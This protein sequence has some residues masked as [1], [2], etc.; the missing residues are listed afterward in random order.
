M[1]DFWLKII[2]TV[3]EECFLENYELAQ[4][5]Q[6]TLS[7]SDF[8]GS[9]SVLLLG[10]TLS[11]LVFLMECIIGVARRNGVSLIFKWLKK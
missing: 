2:L 10:S 3:K 11:L 1:A 7:L 8:S 6:R 4:D 5:K 9:F